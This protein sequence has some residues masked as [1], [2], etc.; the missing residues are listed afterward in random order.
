MYSSSLRCVGLDLKTRSV[1]RASD[2]RE[3]GCGCI[4]FYVVAPVLIQKPLGLEFCLE[5]APAIL[6][7]LMSLIGTRWS[8]VAIGLQ[9]NST[10]KDDDFGMVQCAHAVPICVSQCE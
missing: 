2:T 5:G 8:A 10:Q 3:C 9:C 7:K 4:S 6:M 1:E